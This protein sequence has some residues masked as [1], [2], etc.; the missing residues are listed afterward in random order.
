VSSST[1]QVSSSELDGRRRFIYAGFWTVFSLVNL[2]LGLYSGLSLVGLGFASVG[3]GGFLLAGYS[4]FAHEETVPRPGVFGRT[5]RREAPEDDAVN[6]TT[7]AA[8]VGLALV[9]LG[10]TFVLLAVIFFG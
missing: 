8:A 10:I 3:L 5:M 1:Q 7:R 2:G 6:P 4:V 9:L